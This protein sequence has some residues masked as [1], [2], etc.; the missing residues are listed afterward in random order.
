LHEDW[1]TPDQV[2]V[3]DFMVV[4][5]IPSASVSGYW[6]ELLCGSWWWIVK[7]GWAG[8]RHTPSNHSI[9]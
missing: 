1:G 4:R 8:P 6:V 2:F 5:P 9:D 3:V 7:H